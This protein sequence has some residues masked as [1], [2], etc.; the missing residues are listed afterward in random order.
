MPGDQTSKKM[1]WDLGSSATT[2]LFFIDEKNLGITIS[3]SSAEAASKFISQW[4]ANTRQEYLM[5]VP[6]I[7][8]PTIH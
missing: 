1:E 4:H 3:F 7:E 6:M 5:H 2:S 8:A